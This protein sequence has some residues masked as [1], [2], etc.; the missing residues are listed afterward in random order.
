MMGRNWMGWEFRLFWRVL[1]FLVDVAM[2]NTHERA[3]AED[4]AALRR[5][6]KTEVE[7]SI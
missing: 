1:L 5:E 2:E 4:G 3:I 6:L 7:R